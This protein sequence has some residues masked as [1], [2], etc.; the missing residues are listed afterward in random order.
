MAEVQKTGEAG[1]QTIEANEFASLLQKEFKPQTSR[2]KEEVEKAVRTLAEQA[3]KTS[4]IVSADV[5]ETIKSLIS[6]IDKKFIG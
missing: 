6:E 4:V 3:L 5:V 2:A 1:A